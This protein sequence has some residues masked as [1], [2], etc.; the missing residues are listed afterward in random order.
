MS[1]NL[2]GNEVLAID[3]GTQGLSVILWSSER[4]ELVGVGDARYEHDYIPGLPDGR[5]EQYPHY[6]SDALRKAMMAL[7]NDIRQKR[8]ESIDR[9]A[10]IGVTGHMHCMVRRD[11]NDRKPFGGDMWNDPRGVAESRQLT[12]LLGEH[13][14]ARWTGCHILARMQSD[15][16][17]WRKVTGV[18]VTSGSLVHDLTGQWVL[19][20]GDAT[21]MF[22]N[23]DE[24]GQFDRAKLRKIDQ[25]TG[26]RFKP[27][28][29]LVPR[30][31]PAGQIAA[32]LNAAG[33]ELLG[34]LPV[35][36]PVAPPEGD[37]QTTLVA[38]AA[39]ELELALSAGTSFTG[40]LPCRA[41]VVAESET[42][43]VLQTPDLLTMLMV[44][45]R[46]GTI[47]FAQY[48]NAIAGLSGNPFGDVADQLTDLARDVPTDCQ[49][50]MLWGFFQG[51]NV[52]ELPHAKAT[53]RGAGIELLANPGVLA[54]LLLESPCMTMRYGLEN[55][56]SKI[57]AIRKV[58]LTGGVLKSKDGFAP[59]MFADI[60][61]V[62]VVGRPG[63][64]EG[65][66]K[67]AAL[68]AA[69]MV[70]VQ[71]GNHSQTLAEF[72]R[73]QTT[74]HEQVWQPDAQ[75]RSRYDQRYE[76]FAA[77]VK[78]LRELSAC[79]PFQADVQR[80]GGPTIQALASQ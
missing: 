57:G 70:Q 12:A 41:K 46:N 6:W 66:A 55:L 5:L 75:R 47:G 8:G 74:G 53:L 58:I 78:Q 1:P 28:E 40:N 42:V 39:D 54:R 16:D 14:P 9:V 73:G 44:C 60:L 50:A 11:A 67:G 23:L 56:R 71:S 51:E 22:G 49:G 26:H 59:Q 62:P 17:E 34:G 24:E 35:G 65:T 36:T 64:E 10:A 15:P 31:V 20:P 19:G 13:M 52:V 68:L 48:V 25:L 7:R 76:R 4:R 27:L 30:V 45:A 69:Y 18:S 79:D 80:P 63:D 61:G 72:A 33:S 29:L 38:T 3:A 43:N 37:Q 77:G 2:T 32:R 21:G